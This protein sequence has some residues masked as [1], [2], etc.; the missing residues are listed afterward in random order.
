MLVGQARTEATRH[1]QKRAQAAERIEGSGGADPEAYAQLVDAHPA[2][3]R[4]WRRRSTSST[5][6]AGRSRATGTPWPRSRA[7]SAPWTSTRSRSSQPMRRPAARRGR[8]AARV[9]RHAAADAVARRPQRPGG[10]APRD[11]PLDARRAGPVADEHH[12]PGADRGAAARPGPGHGPRRSCG[13]SSRWSSRR[14]RRRR[15]SSSTSGRWCSTTWGSCPT[16]RRAA[17][18]R[19]RRAHV[20][21]EF[22]SMGADRRLP[23]DVEST[24]FRVLDEALGAYLG[25]G[26]RAGHAAARL[27]RGAGGAP[28]RRADRR[29]A[30]GSRRGA[31][32]RA[33]RRRPGRDQADDRGPPRCPDRGRRRGRG[34]GDRRAAGRRAARHPGAGRVHR[35][36]GGDPRRR[37][38]AAARRPA[39]AS[40]G[41]RAPRRTRRAQ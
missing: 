41:G 2:R 31:A 8:R 15:T 22:D 27:D 38:R 33:D 18:D 9:D 40:R 5:A 6:S 10:P 37:R 4:S 39:A 16:L 20:P 19:G 3:R 26:A 17:R 1:E 29:A 23:Q 32:G 14:S 7:R 28:R 11:R 12:A 13:S 36:D 35:R 34:G 30:R 25:L 24:V 21:V